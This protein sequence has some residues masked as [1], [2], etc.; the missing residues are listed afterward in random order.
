M[1]DYQTGAIG[2]LGF[3]TS[4]A[5]IVIGFLGH[6][7]FIAMLF[8]ISDYRIYVVYISNLCR[9]LYSDVILYYGFS[10]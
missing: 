5:F 8:P 1:S 10:V 3:W 9:Y 7:A 6:W 4:I 2:L